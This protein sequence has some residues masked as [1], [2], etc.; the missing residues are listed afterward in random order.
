MANWIKQGDAFSLPVAAKLNGEY[1]NIADVDTVEFYIG[2]V[3]KL[4][5]GDV[6][7][8]T[9]DSVFLVP[10][11]QEETFRFP[12]NGSVAVDVRVKFV[13]GDVLGPKNMTYVPVFDARSEEVI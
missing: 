7:Y 6:T 2:D 9:D 1:L 5:P 3:R 8:D 10:L 12:A 11:T 13:G 4:Y